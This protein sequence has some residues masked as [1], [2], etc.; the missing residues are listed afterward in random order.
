[1]SAFIKKELNKLMDSKPGENVMDY[2][3]EVL[4]FE[5]YHGQPGEKLI[6]TDYNGRHN[7]CH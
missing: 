7:G 4:F 6:Y 3:M 1:M 5:K 2:S